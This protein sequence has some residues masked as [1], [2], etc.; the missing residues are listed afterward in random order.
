MSTR[1]D[2]IVECTDGTWARI[3]CHFDGYL[4]GV[5][6][7]LSDHYNSQERA[8][9]VVAPG[10]M[11]SLSERCSKPEGHSFDHPVKSYSVYYGRDRG[12]TG[13]AANVGDSL[14]A[15]WPEKDTWTEYTYVWKKDHGWLVG[16]ADEG[17]QTLVPL[18]IALK[19][20]AVPKPDV[21]SPFGVLWSRK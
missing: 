10:D 17:D 15:V 19:G 9:A 8:E 4:E 13:V 21:K 6:Q 1:S 20:E 18:A 3:Y 7:T 14:A 2:I 5:G 12:E 16:N 11:S